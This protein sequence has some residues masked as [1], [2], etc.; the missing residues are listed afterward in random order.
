MS[1]PASE[2]S[3][4]SQPSANPA[5]A[6]PLQ[7]SPLNYETPQGKIPT[8]QMTHQEARTERLRR[9]KRTFLSSILLRP[10]AFITPLFITPIFYKYLGG[11]LGFGLYQSTVAFSMFVLMANAGLSLGMVNKLTDCKVSDDKQLAQRYVSSLFFALLFMAILG[12]LIA[13]ATIPFVNWSTLFKFNNARFAAQMPWSI[14]LTVVCTLMGLAMGVPVA[15]YT[16]YQDLEH[17]NYWDAASKVTIFFAGIAVTLT[18][19]GLISVAAAA[20]GTPVLIRSINCLVLFFHEKPWLRP[21]LKH[22]SFELVKQTL[23]QS[24]CFFLLSLSVMLLFQADKLMITFF[25]GADKNSAFSLVGQLFLSGYALCLIFLQPLWPAYGESMR[26]GDFAW[27]NRTVRMSLFVL[28]GCLTVWGMIILLF[29]KFIFRH[30]LHKD[31]DYSNSLVLAM[32]ATFVLRAW[33]DCRSTVLNSANVLWPQ[34]RLLGTHA[35]LNLFVGWFLGKHLH[36]GVEGIA[37]S[38]PI[39]ALMT[40]TWGYP[41][42]LARFFRDNKF[43]KSSEAILITDADI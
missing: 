15:I 40:T 42:L 38:T 26:R 12:S 21:S 17:N 25:L 1:D 20:V 29:G 27:V 8:V 16:A 37:W 31:I 3:I 39:T 6:V 43:V 33:V 28:C 23:A 19:F 32:T 11:D 14:W 7:P 34:L 13:S 4:D 30:W 5:G 22:F 36:Y 10:L 9:L 24:V 41:L 2:T 35:V 18:P